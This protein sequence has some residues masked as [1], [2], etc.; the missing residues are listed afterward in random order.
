MK[1]FDAGVESDVD[2]TREIYVYFFLFLAYTP[3]MSCP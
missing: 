1:S 2:G 3:S